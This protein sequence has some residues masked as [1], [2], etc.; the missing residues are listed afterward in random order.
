M[1]SSK[2]RKGD[3]SKRQYNALGAHQP[4]FTLNT[5][6][7]LRVQLDVTIRGGRRGQMPGYIRR[8]TNSAM[9]MVV[10]A[11][12]ILLGRGRPFA[13]R[14]RQAKPRPTPYVKGAHPA[15]YAQ[16]H[17]RMDRKWLKLQARFAGN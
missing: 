16:V 12:S 6:H 10:I 14:R 11:E 3:S 17:R 7:R 4:G 13:Y 5:G 8:D 9:G 1:R 2:K 15:W